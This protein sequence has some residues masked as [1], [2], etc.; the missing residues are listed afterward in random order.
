MTNSA[1]VLMSVANRMLRK[2]FFTLAVVCSNFR[3]TAEGAGADVQRASLL[4]RGS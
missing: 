2:I 1:Q 4:H 3:W